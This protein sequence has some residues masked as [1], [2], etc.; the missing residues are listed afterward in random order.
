[1]FQFHS[2]AFTVNIICYFFASIFHRW[3]LCLQL[4]SQHAK[5]VY[6][7]YSPRFSLIFHIM[8]L[9]MLIIA[10][11]VLTTNL[12]NLFILESFSSHFGLHFSVIA[13]QVAVIIVLRFSQGFLLLDFVFITD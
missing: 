10:L 13:H 12:F 1:M 2:F 8:T 7:A 11:T 9:I 5:L 4:L 3:L 6:Q